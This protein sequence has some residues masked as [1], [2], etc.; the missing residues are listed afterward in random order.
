MDEL[1]SDF[2]L[3]EKK[4]HKI[5]NAMLDEMDKGLRGTCLYFRND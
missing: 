1:L 2:D 3:S 5:K 4:L